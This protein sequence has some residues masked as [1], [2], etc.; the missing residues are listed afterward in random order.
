M[1]IVEA[2]LVMYKIKN[3]RGT[4]VLL[5]CSENGTDKHKLDPFNWD[6]VDKASCTG[7]E[8]ERGR[9]RGGG[10]ARGFCNI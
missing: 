2:S 10:R 8:G 5:P 6:A 3:I 7:R 1:Q 4:M 9:R